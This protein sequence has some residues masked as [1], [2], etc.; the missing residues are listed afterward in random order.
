MNSFVRT[1]EEVSKAFECFC[2]KVI[3]NE[4][5]SVQRELNRRSKQEIS[6]CDLPVEYETNLSVYDCYFEDLENKCYCIAG[7]SISNKQLEMALRSLAEDKK[8]IIKLYYFWGMTDKEIARRLNIPRS[9]VQ[10]KRTKSFG[11][12]KKFLEKNIR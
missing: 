3:K 5:I 11:Q 10:Y 1:G 4:A 6:M 7:R 9:T 8:E 2:K 12:M